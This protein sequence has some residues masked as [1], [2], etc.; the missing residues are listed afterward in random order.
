MFVIVPAV[1]PTRRI[2]DSGQNSGRNVNRF[3][4]P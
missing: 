1:R 4:D 3:V 2:G